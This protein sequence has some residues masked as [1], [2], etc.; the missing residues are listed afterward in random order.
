M[1]LDTQTLMSTLAV[2]PLAVFASSWGV[3]KLQT[4]LIYPSNMPENSRTQVDTPDKYN[5]PYENVTIKTSDGQKLQAFTMLVCVIVWIIA[6]L[7]I[8]C[9][10]PVVLISN[11]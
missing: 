4:M 7:A 9:C 11:Y 8:C 5:L 2:I 6:M 1:G 10:L 3:Q